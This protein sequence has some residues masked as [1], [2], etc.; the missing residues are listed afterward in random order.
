MM[1]TAEK[2]Y[3]DVMNKKRIIAN[4]KRKIEVCG[5]DCYCLLLKA[6]S[7]LSHFQVSVIQF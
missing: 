2:E 6:A 3:Q 5:R 7:T 4:D 1:E